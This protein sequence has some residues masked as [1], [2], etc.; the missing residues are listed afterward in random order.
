M[1]SEEYFLFVFLPAVLKWVKIVAKPLF[2]LCMYI[3]EEHFKSSLCVP[4]ALCLC[5]EAFFSLEVTVERSKSELIMPPRA[6]RYLPS[7]FLPALPQLL[8]FCTGGDR[9]GGSIEHDG[10]LCRSR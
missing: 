7:P 3:F 5:S 4:R 10:Y 1:L 6:V 2:F 8:I 9:I